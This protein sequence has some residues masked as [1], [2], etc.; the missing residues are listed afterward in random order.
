MYQFII[1]Q[2]GKLIRVRGSP[3]EDYRANAKER[4]SAVHQLSQPITTERP[5][6][7]HLPMM[8]HVWILCVENPA[9]CAMALRVLGEKKYT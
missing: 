8:F 1:F 3:Q 6:P 7:N 5:V 9:C 2:H 4:S